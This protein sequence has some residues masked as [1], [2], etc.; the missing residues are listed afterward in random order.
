MQFQSKMRKILIIEDNSTKLQHIRDFCI[1]NVKQ[2]CLTDR[3][4][5]NTAQQE[6]IFHGSEYDIIL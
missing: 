6:V 3:Q 1:N 4:S 5:Y 2:S